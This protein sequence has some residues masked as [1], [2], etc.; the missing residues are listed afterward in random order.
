ML[1]TIIQSPKPK[2]SSFTLITDREKKQILN[3]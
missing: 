2:D 3:L 1:I